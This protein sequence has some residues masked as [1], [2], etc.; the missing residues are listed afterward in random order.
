MAKVIVTR[1]I[2]A[3]VADVWAAWDDF[4]NIDR[5][6][7]NLKQSGLINGSA[8]SGLGAE[9]QC[10]LKDGKNYIQER[11]VDYQPE[12]RMTVDIFNGS[13]PLKRAKATIEMTPQAVRRTEL[14]FTMEFTPGMGP[15]GQLMVPMM[16]PQFRR[17]LSG[18]VDANKAYVERG[19]E[20]RRA[21]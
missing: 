18:L 15:L 20:V 19:E 1:I 5:F 14:T 16:K 11:V 6:N 10:D 17:M 8:R 2:D 3:P 7:P 4:G 9:R 12:R 13:L 21:A